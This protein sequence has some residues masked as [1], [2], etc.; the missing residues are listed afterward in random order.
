MGT[1]LNRGASGGL[2]GAKDLEI[3]H[4]SQTEPRKTAVHG[5]TRSMK[6]AS[7]TVA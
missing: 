3:D 1:W 7:L 5:A 4:R 6:T 2:A